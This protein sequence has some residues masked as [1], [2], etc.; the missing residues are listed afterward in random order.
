M[1]LTIAA[2]GA[3]M[4]VAAL[5]VLVA[6]LRFA[7]RGYAQEERYRRQLFDA[8]LGAL[9]RLREAGQIREDLIA[10][11]SHEF[12]TPLTAIRG[13][14]ATL[15]SRGDRIC[16]DDRRTLLAGIVEHADRLGRLLEDMLL[17]ASARAATDSG[18]VADVTAALARFRLGQA[19][20]PVV[21]E[22]DSGL[23]A[24]VDSVSLDQVVRALADHVRADAR[25]DRPVTLRSCREAGEVV[26]DLLYTTSRSEEELR[27]LFEPFGSRE[28]ARS[29]RPASLALYVV[30]RLVEAH[31]GRTAAG[32]DG[33]RLR[34]RVALRALRPVGIARTSAD[35]SDEAEP[36][37]EPARA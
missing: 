7:E 28:A 14:A 6:A 35:G 27:R 16:P 9:S 32:R 25:K 4:L 19:R 30:Q 8:E 37:I 29:G 18:A 33:D 36:E 31:G 15:A 21:S 24:Y 20:P 22:V 34:V 2:I 11:V 3:A 23:A 26:V 5:V 13:S 10:S 1:P 17:A 12:R